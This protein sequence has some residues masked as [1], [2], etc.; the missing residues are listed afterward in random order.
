MNLS[1][2]PDSARITPMLTWDIPL[3]NQGRGFWRYLSSTW[4]G[5]ASS[6]SR[7]CQRSTIASACPNLVMRF[8]YAIELESPGGIVTDFACPV[9]LEQPCDA[10]QIQPRTDTLIC[11]LLHCVLL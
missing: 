11:P 10:F 9:K 8:T 7:Y 5:C 3:T 2:Q 6:A 1:T 4:T